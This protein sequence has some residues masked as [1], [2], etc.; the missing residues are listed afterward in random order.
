MTACP[1]AGFTVEGVDITSKSKTGETRTHSAGIFHGE[2]VT[3]LIGSECTADDTR[4]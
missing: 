4:F 3:R 2:S 1:H